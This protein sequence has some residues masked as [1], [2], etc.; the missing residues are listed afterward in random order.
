M[1]LRPA[2]ICTIFLVSLSY[3]LGSV[4]LH[5]NMFYLFDTCWRIVTI[6]AVLFIGKLDI[7]ITRKQFLLLCILFVTEMIVYTLFSKQTIVLVAIS[8][9][10][11]PILEEILFR[12]W[13]IESIDGTSNQKIILS[14]I[15]FA[16]YHLKNARVLTLSALLYQIFYAGVIIG[17]I[18]AWIRIR[19]GSIF[20]GILLHSANNLIADIITPHLIP[21]IAKRRDDFR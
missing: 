4:F 17:P 11:A 6:L 20:A 16:L 9:M 8:L 21:F 1:L 14:S 13:V 7:R 19:T 12:G 15:L 2:T 5:G 10:L 18:L 3:F